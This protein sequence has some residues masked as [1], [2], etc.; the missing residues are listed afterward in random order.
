VIPRLKEMRQKHFPEMLFLMESMNSR[1]VLVDMQ[2]WLGYERVFT[3]EPLGK[4]GGLALF[5]KSG[6]TVDLKY[7]DKN[8]MDM[9]VQFGAVSFFGSCIYGDPV[10][11]L[12]KDNLERLSRIGIGRK[13][14]WC[15]V[16]DFNDILHN[17]EKLGGP[18]RSDNVF[19]PFAEMLQACDMVEMASHGNKFTWAGRRYDIWVQSRLDRAFG[20]KDWFSQF[21]ASNQT[22]MDWRG[23]DHRPVMIKLIE[24]QDTYRGQFRFD[25]RLL[26][27]PNVLE[28]ISLAWSNGPVTR[29][30]SVSDSL[31]V[32]RKSL[33]QWKKVNNLNSKDKIFQIEHALE[34]EQSSSFPRLQVVWE[35][36][37]D[38]VSAYKEEELY[39]HQ[40]SRAF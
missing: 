22:F 32:C 5:I 39:W 6:V 40:K 16:G 17:G 13:E 34:V 10:F 7:F 35:I 30:S 21:P 20:N 4:S 28:A 19:L 1:N 9:H 12:K 2:V 26:N 38:L 36:K 8:L 31:R 11:K 27:K 29:V 3:V 24:S 37:Q 14:S 23:S 15:M 18:L 25:K 33:S